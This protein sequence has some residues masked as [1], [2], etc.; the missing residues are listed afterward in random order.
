M[1]I[2]IMS[3][4]VENISDLDRVAV[5]IYGLTMCRKRICPATY[6]SLYECKTQIFNKAAH[7]PS[8]FL[9]RIYWLLVKNI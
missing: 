7:Q 3:L 8:I 1:L 5:V 4:T 9:T 2:I 6:I